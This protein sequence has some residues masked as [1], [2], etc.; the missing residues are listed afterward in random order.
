MPVI[1]AT[2]EAEVGGSQSKSSSGRSTRPYL[3]NKLKARRTKGV[4]QVVEHLPL[5]YETLSSIEY[6][7][8]H[9]KDQET[10]RGWEEGSSKS[11][12]FHAYKAAE[13]G[14]FATKEN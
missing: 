8:P 6:C 12:S 13:P 11:H 14:A 7:P 10:Q 2:Q 1:P 9:Q 4:A 3:K 5:R